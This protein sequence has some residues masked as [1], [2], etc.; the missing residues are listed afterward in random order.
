MAD[1]FTKKKR[2]EIMSKIRSKNTRPELLVRKFLF[3]QGFRYRLH[4]NELIGKPD[5]VLR[6]YHTV[7]FVNGCLWHG[8]KICNHN[9]PKTKQD[10]W[11]PKINRN[12]TKDLKNR[13]ELQKIGWKI[14]TIWECQLKRKVL[15]KTLSN[16]KSKIQGC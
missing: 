1:V 16:L 12:I 3:S 4:S 2:S 6:K 10:Y 11:I 7:V 15:D 8:H 13:R 9:F 5:I 14:I